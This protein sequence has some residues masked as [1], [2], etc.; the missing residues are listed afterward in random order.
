MGWAHPLGLTRA[1]EDPFMPSLIGSSFT[2]L[3]A[4]ISCLVLVE[5]KE[6]GGKMLVTPRAFQVV[7]TLL[8]VWLGKASQ[9]NS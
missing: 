7:F 8:H 9:V 2:D 6:E 1:G 5:G 4:L 3:E